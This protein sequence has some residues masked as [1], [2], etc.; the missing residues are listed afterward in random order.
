MVEQH[1][2]DPTLPDADNPEWT[3]DD[4]AK[5]KPASEVLPKLFS[6]AM[7]AEM[8]RPKRG[9]PVSASPK[10]H[11]NLRLDADVVTAFQTTGRGWQ[12]RLNT[13]LKDWLKTHR[14]A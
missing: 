4:F 2:P 7:A 11:I 12:T 5:A 10:M 3:A 8:L 14:S 13:A 6:A 1:R 9:R